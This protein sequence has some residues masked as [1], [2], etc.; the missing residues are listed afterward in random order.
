[1]V[2]RQIT[3]SAVERPVYR[4]QGRTWQGPV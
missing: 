3:S 2:E 1:V 4:V